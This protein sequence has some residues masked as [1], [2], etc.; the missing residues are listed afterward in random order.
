[1][2]SSTHTP[3]RRCPSQR[4]RR[5]DRRRLA[6]RWIRSFVLDA[7]AF[8]PARICPA[9]RWD[10]RFP[11]LPPPF[12]ARLQSPRVSGRML[13]LWELLIGRLCAAFGGQKK[14]RPH[15]TAAL[16]AVQSTRG[17]RRERTFCVECIARAAHPRIL[18]IYIYIYVYMC[19]LIVYATRCLPCFTRII[20]EF[21]LSLRDVFTRRGCM[22]GIRFVW[23]VS[24]GERC[25]Q[26][27]TYLFWCPHK[28][29]FKSASIFC[30]S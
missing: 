2:P 20:F 1:M 8:A 5:S 9:F 14:P 23:W 7:E 18:Y 11:S 4:A 21:E 13:S 19:T 10:D 16:K 26:I 12:C 6:R 29:K 25:V 3:C 15:P 30:R 24:R 17:A 22:V 28:L 27:E